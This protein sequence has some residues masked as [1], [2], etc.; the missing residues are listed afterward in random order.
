MCK[1]KCN[2]IQFYN[3][4]NFT[5]HVY[6]SK[7]PPPKKKV[8]GNNHTQF[9]EKWSFLPPL[10]FNQSDS[11][12]K[13]LLPPRVCCFLRW[14]FLL[15]SHLRPGYPEKVAGWTRGTRGEFQTNSYV[16]VSEKRVVLKCRLISCHRNLFWKKIRDFAT[17]AENANM[18]SSGELPDARCFYIDV[19]W[20]QNKNVPQPMANCYV[21]N[22]RS[23]LAYQN[24]VS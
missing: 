2:V 15:P 7:Q 18:L 14:G 22:R 20:F 13:G 23:E 24:I 10:P 11:F 1:C 9:L 17:M 21:L 5:V 8:P 12:A 6:W 16:E 19:V 4:R 3:S